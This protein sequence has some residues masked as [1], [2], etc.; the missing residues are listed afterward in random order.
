MGS[1]DRLANKRGLHNS[2]SRITTVSTGRPRAVM[3]AGELKGGRSLK[4]QT[5]RHDLPAHRN[6]KPERLA[7]RER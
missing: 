7:A 5:V 3:D 4:Q 6:G 2:P 1:V